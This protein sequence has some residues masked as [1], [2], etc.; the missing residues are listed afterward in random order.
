MQKG[1]DSRR[2]LCYL[3]VSLTHD[4]NGP[5]VTC[6]PSADLSSHWLLTIDAMNSAI[7]CRAAEDRHTATTEEQ[8]ANEVRFKWPGLERRGV[9][10]ALQLL[11]LFH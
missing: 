6:T 8:R 2:W 4:S 3:R 11:F 9:A 5:C 7:D 1:F 10:A